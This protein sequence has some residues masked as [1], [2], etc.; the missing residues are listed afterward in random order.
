MPRPPSASSSL[1]ST[2]LAGARVIPSL[3]PCPRGASLF[4]Q[5]CRG[6]ARAPG[7]AGDRAGAVWRAGVPLCLPRLRASRR[8]AAPA[9]RDDP[10]ERVRPPQR[11]SLAYGVLSFF[12]PSAFFS[13]GLTQLLSF[14]LGPQVLQIL[15][16]ARRASS[17]S[18]APSRS[19]QAKPGCLGNHSS[20]PIKTASFPEISAV[21]QEVRA[22]M[23]VAQISR[24]FTRCPWPPQFSWLLH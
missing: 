5:G 13:L 18:S 17:R 20:S 2:E 15:S 24:V 21:W 11:F 7:W 12:L 8:C 16:Q 4:G 1:L 3:F 14:R 9:G 10:G 22:Q 19:V 23:F 6:L